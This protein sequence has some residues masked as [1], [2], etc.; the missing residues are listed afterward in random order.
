MGEADELLQ[1][2]RLDVIAMIIYRT[3]LDNVVLRCP[4]ALVHFHRAGDGQRSVSYSIQREGEE[5]VPI[6]GAEGV[7]FKRTLV[8]VGLR[9]NRVDSQGDRGGRNTLG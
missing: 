7:N 5:Y 4:N 9:G 3:G 2:A 6:N 8:G 1:G